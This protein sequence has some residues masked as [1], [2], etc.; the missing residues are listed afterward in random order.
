MQH[1]KCH[2]ICSVVLSFL[3]AVLSL[4]NPLITSFAVSTEEQPPP[5]L[6]KRVEDF[7]NQSNNNYVIE[8]GFLFDLD[9]DTIVQYNPSKMITDFIDRLIS[10]NDENRYFSYNEARD[11]FVLK[12]PEK[13][14]GHTVRFIGNYSFAYCKYPIVDIPACVEKIGD[15]AFFECENLEKL[16]LKEGLKEIGRYAFY[17]VPYGDKSIIIPSSVNY[18]DLQEKSTSLILKSSNTKVA[19]SNAE[20]ENLFY[21]GIPE[22]MDKTNVS[23]DKNAVLPSVA[24]DHVEISEKKLWC[25]H[26][27]NDGFTYGYFIDP[28][29]MC[30]HC[31]API[32]DSIPKN[33]RCSKCDSELKEENVD[34]IYKTRFSVS[35]FIELYEAEYGSDMRTY[36]IN[37]A[38]EE[39]FLANDNTPIGS[40]DE[41]SECLKENSFGVFYWDGEVKCD[42]EAFIT[43]YSS[44]LDETPDEITVSKQYKVF[45]TKIFND[46][47]A[48]ERISFTDVSN[49]RSFCISDT[50]DISRE[51]ANSIYADLDNFNIGVI[52]S[53]LN[54][55]LA[56]MP[57]PMFE[58]CPNL[59]SISIY[60]SKDYSELSNNEALKTKNYN[61]DAIG[62]L[63]KYAFNAKF[64]NYE[65]PE[66]MEYDDG[67]IYAD[68]RTCLVAVL[69]D[70]E[71]FEMPASVQYVC[72]FAF[73]RQNFKNIIWSENCKYIP[74]GCFSYSSLETFDYNGVEIIEDCAFYHA[75]Y[76]KVILPSTVKEFGTLVFEGSTVTSATLS[77]MEI[78]K[79]SYGLFSNCQNLKSIVYDIHADYLAQW[80]GIKERET[81]EILFGYMHH[82][83]KSNI[84]EYSVT[85]DYTFVGV[86]G[87]FSFCT[88]VES[89]HIGASC[90]TLFV[91][92]IFN[93]GYLPKL[94]K[95]TAD[96][97]EHECSW[98]D[99]QYIALDNVLY[100]H[101]FYNSAVLYPQGLNLYEVS[102]YNSAMF[103]NSNT[104]LPTYIKPINKM[105]VDWVNASGI[106]TLDIN[107]MY[108]SPIEKETCLIE[109]LVDTRTSL[110]GDEVVLPPNFI[111]YSDTIPEGV[112]IPETVTIIDDEAHKFGIIT[113]DEKTVDLEYENVTNRIYVI[114]NYTEAEFKTTSDGH[115]VYVGNDEYLSVPADMLPS[116]L[117]RLDDWFYCNGEF[118]PYHQS[119][120]KSIRI[121]GD[122]DLLNLGDSFVFPETAYTEYL[123][124][125]GDAETA[126][127]GLLLVNL[128]SSNAYN[129][130][131]SPK[132]VKSLFP[133]NLEMQ[134]IIDKYTWTDGYI[135]FGEEMALPVIQVKNADEITD[136][137]INKCIG[138]YVS[139]WK[140][141]LYEIL[142]AY[143][144]VPSACLLKFA[145]EKGLLIE[146]EFD[147]ASMNDELIFI[148]YLNAFYCS[149]KDELNTIFN[150]TSFAEFKEIYINECLLFDEETQTLYGD[151][152]GFGFLLYPAYINGV[153]VKNISITAALRYGSR[154]SCS[155]FI[156]STTEKVGCTTPKDKEYLQTLVAKQTEMMLKLEGITDNVVGDFSQAVAAE[157]SSDSTDN[158]FALFLDGNY[159]IYISPYNPYFRQVND[160]ILSADGSVCYATTDDSPFLTCI[161]THYA[162]GSL[163]AGS[164]TNVGNNIAPHY[165][166]SQN[167]D[168]PITFDDTVKIKCSAKMTYA[169]CENCELYVFD[170]GYTECPKC[171][172]ELKFEQEE[173]C[174][175]EFTYGVNWCV[176]PYNDSKQMEMTRITMTKDNSYFKEYCNNKEISEAYIIFESLDYSE[177]NKE[178]LN[179]A[180]SAYIDFTE[181]VQNEQPSVVNRNIILSSEHSTVSNLGRISD[182]QIYIRRGNVPERYK[183]IEEFL[184][185]KPFQTEATVILETKKGILNIVSKNINGECI[186]AEYLLTDDNGVTVAT[187]NSS[188][189]G[190][191]AFMSSLPYGEYTVSQ[192][193]VSEPYGLS[194]A[195]SFKITEDGQ[196]VDL[197]FVNS[198]ACIYSVRIPRTI[199][200][201]GKSGTA[202]IT[203]SVKGRLSDSAQ[204][205]VTPSELK[206]DELAYIDK[207][208]SIV[209][210]L[211][212]EK[213]VW[214][215]EDISPDLWQDAVWHIEAPLT[216]GIWK[217]VLPVTVQIE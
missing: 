180:L 86:N 190:T 209:A 137:F 43:D 77:N 17:K 59:K 93:I 181:G 104:V 81:D 45:D 183:N 106:Q 34:Y 197:E 135:H 155:S 159:Y 74:F 52:K 63:L 15:Y 122:L 108:L 118:F 204:I 33:A 187:L 91:P 192:T 102:S 2:Y 6:P 26:T 121:D 10:A 42:K 182:T 174:S 8:N 11:M 22:F 49:F 147:K 164:R 9:T 90:D 72:N 188:S 5:S 100:H 210:T 165:F 36:A 35:E 148:Q 143:I 64:E 32:F 154:Y 205:S 111:H 150:I 168:K 109:N 214:K 127:V 160:E 88:N 191:K 125:Y 103:V 146:K 124:Y 151:T 115:T 7:Y 24:D 212:A 56:S 65:L 170:G 173:M 142:G 206:L 171:N 107:H 207:K 71:R 25:Y 55:I 68:M 27:E 175:A 199:I 57:I 172:S 58:N 18:I 176:V 117:N 44:E 169:L 98:Q 61:I 133:D 110:W 129:I 161:P 73:A 75:D 92:D 208:E 200:L 156:M 215:S 162:A 132:T 116:F 120:L 48:L 78:S 144:T 128:M 31:N 178:R 114:P 149:A 4:T 203:V 84:K 105:I 54:T 38:I 211:N 46:N 1:E 198:M 47:E 179:K 89:I 97:V 29:Y 119:R 16:C 39:G 140:N 113:D 193:G 21:T 158:L 69:E 141:K 83:V 195:Q 96:D 189:D 185:T 40:A 85:L 184:I 213:T 216:A 167:L 20:F 80:E 166:L 82:T 134:E 13:I 95:I 131:L 23:V 60:D 145:D 14:A 130:E 66:Y 163:T 177:S 136:D 79:Y 70:K 51:F 28:Q 157:L 217:G 153:P 53:M 99:Q 76:K 12:I 112:S 62:L 196:T 67:I 101:G 87:F 139:A 3:I 194:N 94:I 202:D 123:H 186:D 30:L 152:L 50:V 126:T 138:E 41:I 19:Y 201:D 37:K